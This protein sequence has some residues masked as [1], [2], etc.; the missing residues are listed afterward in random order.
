VLL[1]FWIAF[2]SFCPMLDPRFY[3]IAVSQHDSESGAPQGCRR[4]LT[5]FTGISTGNFP[6][7]CL[8]GA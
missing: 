5:A 2:K 3:G 6:K 7:S 4:G 1:I 8:V